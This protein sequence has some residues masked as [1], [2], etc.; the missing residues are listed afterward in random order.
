MIQS[1]VEKLAFFKSQVAREVWSEVPRVDPSELRR[2]RTMD[3]ATILTALA[4]HSKRGTT[5][6][7]PVKDPLT[8]RWH[9]NF[10]GCD[11]ELLLIS[12]KFLVTRVEKGG[13]GA[14]DQAL[15]LLRADFKTATRLL[16]KRNLY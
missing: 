12:P 2:W 10:H 11:F 4:G 14:V 15:H 8:I 7:D 6:F 13:G 5:T 3:A 9:A 16:R 1:I